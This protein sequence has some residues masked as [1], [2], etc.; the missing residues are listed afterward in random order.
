MEEHGY[1]TRMDNGTAICTLDFGGEQTDVGGS[2][3]T[4]LK[5]LN[6]ANPANLGEAHLA[7]VK[8]QQMLA[9]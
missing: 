9:L 1:G 3:L 2:S 8:P 7:E 5:H 4:V 6:L